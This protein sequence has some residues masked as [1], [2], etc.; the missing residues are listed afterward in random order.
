MDYNED[1][2][3]YNEDQSDYNEDQLDYNEGRLDYIEDQL[4]Y[5]ISI[6]NTLR[7]KSL[8]DRLLYFQ[9]QQSLTQFQRRSLP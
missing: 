2:L 3:D 9:R 7:L 1:L 4:A 8:F 6:I 5:E